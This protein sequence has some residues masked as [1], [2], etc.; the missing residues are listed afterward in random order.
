MAIITGTTLILAT[1]TS[2]DMTTPFTKESLALLL[3][4]TVFNLT[5]NTNTSTTISCI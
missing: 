4:L 3:P 5:S 1:I 2:M